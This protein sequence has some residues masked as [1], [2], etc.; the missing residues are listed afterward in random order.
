MCAARYQPVLTHPQ[1][2]INTVKL[3]EVIFG[4]MFPCSSGNF[5][6]FPL[7][8]FFPPGREI[9]FDLFSAEFTKL[10]SEYRETVGSCFSENSVVKSRSLQ[11]FVEGELT[12]N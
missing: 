4:K 11:D 7:F 12:S 1:D 2:F 6:Q 8:F 3:D 10:D 5:Q 9:S